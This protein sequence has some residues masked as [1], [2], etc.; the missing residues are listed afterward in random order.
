[1]STYIA[2]A[3]EAL[4]AGE[5]I[6]LEGDILPSVRVGL[7]FQ[8]AIA[9]ALIAIAQ[10]LEATRTKGMFVLELVEETDGTG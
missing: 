5:D 8:A 1:M 10:E 2:S 6:P 4:G 9:H 7:V 3:I